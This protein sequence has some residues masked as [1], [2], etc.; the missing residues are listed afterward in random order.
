MPQTAAEPP[1]SHEE[2]HMKKLKLSALVI[3]V[4]FQVRRPYRLARA[5]VLTVAPGMHVRL[6]APATFRGRLF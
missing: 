4:A 2:H 1:E 6:C 3:D 5:V